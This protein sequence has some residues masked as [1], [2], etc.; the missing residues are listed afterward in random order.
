MYYRAIFTAP[1]PSL[2]L[3]KIQKLLAENIVTALLLYLN[4]KMLCMKNVY[5]I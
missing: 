3:T 4:A 1:H 5:I 2:A